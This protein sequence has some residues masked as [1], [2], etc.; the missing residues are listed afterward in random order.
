VCRAG[1]IAGLFT[2]TAAMQQFDDRLL[3]IDQPLQRHLPEFS[4]RSRFA[5]S[6]PMPP[7]PTLTNSASNHQLSS[8]LFTP[9]LPLA[10]IF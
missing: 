6:P 5:D 4:I 10:G 1:A 9:Q 7:R 3:D 2:A 8:P